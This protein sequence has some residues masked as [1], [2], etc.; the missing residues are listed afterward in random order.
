MLRNNSHAS[1]NLLNY[2]KILHNNNLK[3]SNLT[4]LKV[5]FYKYIL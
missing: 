3:S 4:I 2:G 5:T 1:S